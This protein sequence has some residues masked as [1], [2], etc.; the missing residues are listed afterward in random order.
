MGFRSAGAAGTTNKL[1]LS[2]AAVG[3]AGSMAGLGTFATFTDTET[4]STAIDSGIVA[5]TI[6]ATGAANRLDVPAV[7]IVPGDSIQRAVNLTVDSTT[8]SP[9]KDIKLTTTG[10]GGTA[11]TTNVTDGL[12]LTI[13][14]CSVAWTESTAPYT[15]TCTGTGAVETSV[16]A[17]RAIV[18]AD[19]ALSNLG[20]AAG[21]TNHLVVTATLPATAGNAFQNLASTI[22]YAF[23]GTQRDAAAK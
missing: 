10:T 8:T 4:G 16:L 5:M 18:G 19:L 15:Y 2:V 9:L 21:S 3:V 7:D 13:R 23:T 14:K 12:Q 17:S 22:T 11:L 20:L 1:L 6:G